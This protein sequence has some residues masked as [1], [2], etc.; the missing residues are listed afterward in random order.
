MGGADH[1][2][3]AD[4][5]PVAVPARYLGTWEGEGSGLD[6]AVPMGTFRLT[7]Q[8]ADVGEE[9][10]LLRQTDLFGGVCNDVLTLQK[11]TN[12]EIVATSVGAKDN[13]DGCNPQT[14]KW[15]VA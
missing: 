2:A 10:G 6:D 1:S 9:L 11:V 5:A 15:E 8:Q 7:V 4:T 3:P 14:G 13:Y 12:T